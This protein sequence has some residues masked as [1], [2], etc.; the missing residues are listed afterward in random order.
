MHRRKQNLYILPPGGIFGGFRGFR[1]KLTVFIQKHNI[2]AYN[3]VIIDYNH[4]S[5]TKNPHFSVYGPHIRISRGK[6]IWRYTI[7]YI[8]Y[9][10]I[11]T[12]TIHIASYM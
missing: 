11:L 3:N 4:Y 5:M 1:P 10:I 8:F 6:S 7:D 9:N 2:I 12:I